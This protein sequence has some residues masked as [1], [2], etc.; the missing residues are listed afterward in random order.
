MV[1][2]HAVMLLPRPFYLKS[3]VTFAIFPARMDCTD[4]ENYSVF[5][6]FVIS[7]QVDNHHG[8]LPYQALIA[9]GLQLLDD[10]DS[11]KS[12][13]SGGMRMLLLAMLQY[14]LDKSRKFQ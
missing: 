13:H 12:E 7:S 3:I 2:V 10:D 11:E 8:C 5:G 1:L 4:P 6:P 9:Y 14:A